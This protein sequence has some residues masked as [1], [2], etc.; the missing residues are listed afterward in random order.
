MSRVHPCF[1]EWLLTRPE[2]V[3]KLAAEFPPM[4]EIVLDDVTYRVMG[5]T[6]DDELLITDRDPREEYDLAKSERKILC[7]KH[8]R[9]DFV[10]TDARLP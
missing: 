2:C 9:E 6:E 10:R 7:A 4:T 8:V 3:Q 1:E 5:Y